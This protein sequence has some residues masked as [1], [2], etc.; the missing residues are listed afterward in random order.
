MGFL[1]K[2][3][4]RMLFFVIIAACIL[5]IAFKPDWRIYET[6][7]IHDYGKFVGNYDNNRPAEF[8]NSFFP[9]QISDNFSSVEY[10]YKAKKFDTY[11]Y[12]AYLAFCIEDDE[13]FAEYVKKL[14][15]LHGDSIVFSYD[16]TYAEYP[17]SNVYSIAS[18][19]DITGTN[20]YRIV[21]A[22]LGKI[23]VSRADQRIIYIALGLHD[24]GG[25]RTD[26]LCYF[27]NKFSID[28]VAYA[29]SAFD[30][31]FEERESKK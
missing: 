29:S 17:I 20:T 27:F 7:G 9:S 30:T 10:H 31:V 28:P 19:K 1:K 6:N 23:L 11:A 2:K 25:T 12:E 15:S 16:N 22:Q 14:S 8:I 3:H 13:L 24:G 26:E 4:I 21:G 5:A 18:N